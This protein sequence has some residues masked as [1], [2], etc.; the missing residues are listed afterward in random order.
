[1]YSTHLE[2]LKDLVDGKTV[3]FTG[4]ADPILYKLSPTGMLVSRYLSS[5]EWIQ[6]GNPSFCF[7]EKWEKYEEQSWEDNI[8]NGI[9]CRVKQTETGKEAIVLIVKFN[10]AAGYYVAANSGFW[11]YAEP[12]SKEEALTYIYG[13]SDETV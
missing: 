12:L 6:A 4:C 9:F 5:K 10:K 8:G 11:A 3:K 2:L 7:I 13:E 1:M